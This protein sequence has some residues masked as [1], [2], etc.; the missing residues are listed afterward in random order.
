MIKD[1]ERI[2]NIDTRPDNK[3]VQKEKNIV[4][5]IWTIEAYLEKTSEILSHIEEMVHDLQRE[6]EYGVEKKKQKDVSQ[7]MK[8]FRKAERVL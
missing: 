3:M 7:D 6:Y 2:R 8:Y 5:A 1:Y 4:D